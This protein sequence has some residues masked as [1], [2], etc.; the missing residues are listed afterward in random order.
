MGTVYA[1]Y[2][3]LLDRRV[4]LKLLSGG[5]DDAAQRSRVLR[6]ARAAAALAHP[7]TVKIFDVGEAEGVAFLAM[8]LLEGETLRAALAR[9]ASIQQKL[10]WLLDAARALAEAHEHGLVHHDVKPENMFVCNDGTLKLLDFGIA[11][12]ADEVEDGADGP[13]S[14]GTDRGLVLGTPRY[15]SPEQRSGEPTDARSDQYAWGLVA[16]ELLT[17]QQPATTQA[18]VELEEV[19]RSKGDQSRAALGATLARVEGLHDEIARAVVRAIEPRREDRFP[20]ME[21][22]VVLLEKPR[23]AAAPIN[24]GRPPP[25]PAPSRRPRRMTWAALALGGGGAAVAAVG[26]ALTLS[27]R[28]EVRA[29]AQGAAEG[30]V[31]CVV[32]RLR[33]HPVGPE[34]LIA[35]L[36]GGTLVVARWPEPRYE[37][38]IDGKLEGFDP[39]FPHK[40]LAVKAWMDGASVR[41]KPTLVV[42]AAAPGLLA[43]TRSLADAA[44]RLWSDGEVATLRADRSALSPA[45]GQAVTGSGDG[46]A[47]ALAEQRFA[48]PPGTIFG[49]Q[50]LVHDGAEPGREPPPA[51]SVDSVPSS[52]AIAAGGGGLGVVYATSALHFRSAD[53]AGRFA[54]EGATVFDVPQAATLEFVGDRPVVFFVARH[55]EAV[56]L[57]ST[58]GAPRG[59]SFPLPRPASAE[60]AGPARPKALRLPDGRV[61]VVWSVRAGVSQAMRLA[62]VREDGTVGPPLTLGEGKS[63]GDPRVAVTRRGVEVAWVDEA[64]RAAQVATVVCTGR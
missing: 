60:P 34:N 37:R 53:A 18:T 62:A 24:D 17:G 52:I 5:R 22:I 36:P 16:I 1:V 15:M 58:V 45:M 48:R 13:S 20:S 8:E 14:L 30:G 38:E 33:A 57:F 2:D 39:F 29:R 27:T 28:A 32:E 21:P 6:E 35:L 54:S 59:T 41:G 64:S 25:R 49:L 44:T 55:G 31:L 40:Q 19:G 51:L 4:A 42:T 63:L 46:V 10:A 7:N 50:I 11:G 9:G 12:R 3:S 43:S 61:V 56:R 47:I 23:S 26:V